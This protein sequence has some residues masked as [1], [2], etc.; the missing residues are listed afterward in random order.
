LRI[1]VMIVSVNALMRVLN[2]RATIK[3]I[4]TTTTSPR[5]RKFLKPFSTARLP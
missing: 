5:M 2:A 1:G 3:P 4:A